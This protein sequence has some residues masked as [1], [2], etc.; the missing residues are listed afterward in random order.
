[1]QTDKA[2]YKPNDKVMFRVLV[3]N[4]EMKPYQFKKLKIKVTD[5]DNTEYYSENVD[6]T[7]LNNLLYESSFAIPD[8]PFPGNWSINVQV[9]NDELISKTFEVKEYILPRFEALI[10]TKQHVV[11]SEKTLNLEI[12][13]KYSFGQ[14]V[15]GKAKV[16]AKVYE[17]R[18]GGQNIS[19]N[20]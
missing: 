2:M 19:H 13:G 18:E 14:L 16:T 11:S 7:T 10:K 9:D 17:V 8:E 15:Q 5:H 20:K 6:Q 3:L 12:S 4:P 1:V